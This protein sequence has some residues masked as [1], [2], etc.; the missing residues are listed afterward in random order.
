MKINNILNG[1]YQFNQINKNTKAGNNKI[2]VPEMAPKDKHFLGII[3]E[4]LT[5]MRFQLK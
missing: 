3:F 1:I 4:M 5:P 2:L